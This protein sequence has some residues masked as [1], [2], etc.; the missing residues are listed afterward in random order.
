[1]SFSLPILQVRSKCVIQYYQQQHTGPKSKHLTLQL[2]NNMKQQQ[3]QAYSGRF[4]AGAAKRLRRAIELLVMSSQPFRMLN[5]VTKRYF[6]HRLSFMTLTIPGHQNITASQAYEQ[7]FSHFLQWL[8]RTQQVK[9]YVWKAE[10]QARGQIHYHITTPAFIHYQAIRDKWNNLLSKAG[11]NTEY[12]KKH[13][14]NDANS[15]DIHQVRHVKDLASY[16]MKEFA[17]SIQNPNGDGKVWDCSINLK[18]HKYYSTTMEHWHEKAIEE[19]SDQ[20]KLYIDKYDYFAIL[21]FV[22]S[23]PDE[24]LSINEI[25]LMDKHLASIGRN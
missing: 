20:G 9:T 19:L 17:K 21:K 8:R 2:S 4:T 18:K 10:V 3:K 23:S 12:V 5:P 14:H 13:G 24:L 15:T 25:N 6:K 22:R 1:M 7:V 11:L 16:L